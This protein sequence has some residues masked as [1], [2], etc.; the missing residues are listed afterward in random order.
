VYQYA[1]PSSRM[2][3]PAANMPS[4][5]NLS[6][7]WSFCIL[8]HTGADGVAG[9]FSTIV[10]LD[11]L[12]WLYWDDGAGDGHPGAWIYDDNRTLLDNSWFN[13]R[14]YESGTPAAKKWLLW[15]SWDAAAGRCTQGVIAEGGDTTVAESASDVLSPN[16]GA[17]SDTFNLGYQ[18]SGNGGFHASVAY[19]CF[20]DHQFSQADADFLLGNSGATLGT[21]PTSGVNYFKFKDDLP[22]KGGG[23]QGLIM[24]MCYGASDNHAGSGSGAAGRD[25]ATDD[26]ALIYNEG[27]DGYDEADMIVDWRSDGPASVITT[28]ENKFTCVDPY[29]HSDWDGF[30]DRQ[31]PG[32]TIG[33]PPYKS[34]VAP[35]TRLL[36]ANKAAGVVRAAMIANSRGT[37]SSGENWGMAAIQARLSNVIGSGCAP[38]V[39]GQNYA[40]SPWGVFTSGWGSSASGVMGTADETGNHQMFGNMGTEGN[41]TGASF[42]VAG[43]VAII[44]GEDNWYFAGASPLA[45]SKFAGTGASADFPCRT[46]LKIL[47]FP[48]CGDASWAAHKQTSGTGAGS[49]IASGNIPS[50]A[51]DTQVVA[52][53][54]SSWDGGNKIL[55]LSGAVA[56]VNVND[57]VFIDGSTPSGQIN[58]VTEVISSTEFRLKYDFVV[59]VSNKSTA[60]FGPLGIYDLAY[61]FGALEVGDTSI[62][63][64]LRLTATHATTPLCVLSVEAYNT[65]E[66]GYIMYPGGASGLGY[67]T[68]ISRLVSDDDGIVALRAIDPDVVFLFLADQ[69]S[70]ADTYSNMIAEVEATLP[71]AEIV[72]VVD[73]HHLYPA[74]DAMR[75]SA[76]TLTE[77]VVMVD[78]S[79]NDTVGTVFEQLHNALPGSPPVA[80]RSDH[81]HPTGEGLQQYLEDEVFPMLLLAAGSGG[82]ASRMVAGGASGLGFD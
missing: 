77:N 59:A 80:W 23:D 55:T 6:Q 29:S 66:T 71:A 41:G 39:N 67:D 34:G 32:L 18:G 63:R 25:L 51:L 54:T 5:L 30:F 48:G 21:M 64:G 35:L 17:I 81:L 75:E 26:D 37:R 45:G 9:D 16:G 43:R 49:E 1:S 15:V 57:A 2:Q 58:I 62:C 65:D 27:D 8:M 46:R 13:T 3:I 69:G 28:G 74:G 12:F 19:A 7:D 61:D 47:K 11:D 82:G 78:P 72:V 24:A 52:Q 56:G 70:D 76:H 53:G 44:V 33:D 38:K 36:A 31:T 40:S 50:G 73:M 68:Q 20:Y 42:P 60:R 22:S 4:E 79:H 10:K 14:I